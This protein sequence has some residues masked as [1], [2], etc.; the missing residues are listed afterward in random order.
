MTIA[1]YS[2]STEEEDQVIY[3]KIR[4][5]SPKTF[6][7]GGLLPKLGVIAYDDHGTAV[8]FVCADM[9]NSIPRAFLDFLQTNPDASPRSRYR[10]VKLAEEFLCAELKRMGYVIIDAI[11]RFPGMAALSQRLGYHIAPLPVHHLH[12]LIP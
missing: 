11:T 10:G 8:A 7:Q 5:W 4:A 2:Y 12:K 1:T 9:S 3:H 6:P